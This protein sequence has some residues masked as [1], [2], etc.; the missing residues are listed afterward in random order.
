MSFM[1]L[2]KKR[3]ILD[4]AFN[5]YILYYLITYALKW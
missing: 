1:F 2:K 4:E 5:F 3:L